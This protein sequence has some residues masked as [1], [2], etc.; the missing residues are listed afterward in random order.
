MATT[1]NTYFNSMLNEYLPNQLLM[2]ELIKR[3]WFLKN[4][5]MD[6]SWKGSNI[7]VPF[8]GTKAST[9]SFG[10]LSASGNISQSK[11]IRGQITGYKEVWGSL[12]FNEADLINHEGKI[13]ENT[14]LKILPKEI[15]MFMDT[16]KQVVSTSLIN[17]SYF[18]KL[19]TN[20]T[21]GGTA[22]VYHIDRFMIDQELELDDD[23]SAS[24]TYYAIAIDVNTA[25]VGT[26]TITLSA[27][28]GGA[29][30]DISAYTT[31]QNAKVYHP[32]VITNGSFVSLKEALLSAANGGSA[33]I[34][35][36]SKLAWPSLQAVNIDG[37]SWSATNILDKLFDAFTTVRRKA[38]G[39]ADTVLMSFKHLGNVMKILESQKGAYLVTKAPNASL[40]GWT[41]IEIT[42]VTGQGLK[43]VGIVE[44]D[45]DVV[46]FLD[47]RSFV[48]RTKGGFRK[49]VDPDDGKNFYTVRN[50]TGYQYIVDNCLF[51]EM[52]HSMPGYNAIVYGISY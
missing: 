29:A 52:E 44:M 11:Y 36:V 47:M 19:A 23:N 33:N 51:G 35:G 46:M 5:E 40:Y 41:E 7:I 32:G 24:A 16:F 4:C 31:A 39:K 48:F 3:D 21:A 8:Q 49:R 20:G 28:R 43:L 6:N 17:G 27:T 26:G 1:T 22:E 42:N 38:K 50:T 15:D 13:T 45:D 10:S 12:I 25:T 30:A 2:E 9:V 14:F 37:S 18:D 34:H